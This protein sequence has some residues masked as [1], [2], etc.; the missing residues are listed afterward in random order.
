[1]TLQYVKSRSAQ[2]G[3]AKAR[4]QGARTASPPASSI[5]I[6]RRIAIRRFMLRRLHS[7]PLVL[8]CSGRA[9]GT[10]CALRPVL[11]RVAPVMVRVLRA[12]G[13]VGRSR[14]PKP[15]VV[16][17]LLRAQTI[18]RPNLQEAQN[19]IFPALRNMLPLLVGKTYVPL[20]N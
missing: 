13:V 18:D 7:E 20:H 1:M 16:Q 14:V 2:P 9:P 19:K 3:R 5:R 4:C 17:G 12:E 6:R 10:G 8:C 11:V 15:W